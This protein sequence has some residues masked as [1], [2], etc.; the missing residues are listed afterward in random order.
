MGFVLVL[1]ILAPVLLVY[2]APRVITELFIKIGWTLIL[3]SL[4]LAE[5]V[6][7]L[8]SETAGLKPLTSQMPDGII[9]I[10]M[11]PIFAFLGMLSIVNGKMLKNASDGKLSDGESEA[12][13]VALTEEEQGKAKK[14]RLAWSLFVVFIGVILFILFLPTAFRMQQ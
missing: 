8:I 7:F 5:W 9:G 1:F 12:K 11:M 10:I 6:D 2:F 3:T 13:D 4:F 14:K